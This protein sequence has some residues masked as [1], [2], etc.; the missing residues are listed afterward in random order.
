MEAS[1][2][3]RGITWTLFLVPAS[4]VDDEGIRGQRATNSGLSSA[5]TAAGK[6][7][8]FVIACDAE[9][10]TRSITGARETGRDAIEGKT[11][12]PAK[13]VPTAGISPASL[14]PPSRAGRNQ[15]PSNLRPTA[16]PL[17]RATPKL[18]RSTLPADKRRRDQSRPR[19]TEETATPG[20]PLPGQRWWS[21]SPQLATCLEI[22]RRRY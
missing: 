22:S 14:T 18:R 4:I 19:G 1:V 10:Y 7:Q 6:R 3:S 2:R 16:D 13:L 5:T 17:L 8:R 15:P 11:S 12:S 9:R 20:P 21:T